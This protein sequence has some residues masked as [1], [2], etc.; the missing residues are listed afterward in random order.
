MKLTSGLIK[1]LNICTSLPPRIQPN[2]NSLMLAEND[3]ALTYFIHHKE[4]KYPMNNKGQD[5]EE[6]QRDLISKSSDNKSVKNILLIRISQ[7]ELLG[8]ELSLS[9]RKFRFNE[10]EFPTRTPI[11]D[12]KYNH[13]RSQK[14]NPFY[15]LNYQLDYLLA[16]YFAEFEIIKG[17]VD[18]FLSNSLKTP[19]TKKLSYE[20]A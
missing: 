18:R 13:P 20:N 9:L 15:L 11:S 14:N 2:R 3:N 17:N 1:Q 10:K 8:S 16:N 5:I 4:E 12:I 19:L 6:D 7:D